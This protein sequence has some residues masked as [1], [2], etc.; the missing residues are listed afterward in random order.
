MAFMRVSKTC[1]YGAFSIS[2]SSVSVESFTWTGNDA[3]GYRSAKTRLG[4]IVPELG[5]QPHRCLSCPV[6]ADDYRSTSRIY[7]MRPAYSFHSADAAG[8]A[9][10]CT[11][12]RI[13]IC[14][15]TRIPS[16]AVASSGADRDPGR[17]SPRLED[18]EHRYEGRNL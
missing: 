17:G 6:I 9:I 11:R 18:K 5:G 2:S 13:A 15:I 8:G 16:V 14:T 1:F 12:T 7:P 4:P 3:A 10:G